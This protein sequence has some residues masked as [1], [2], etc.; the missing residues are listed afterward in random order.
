[1]ARCVWL[2]AA[3][4]DAEQVSREDAKSAERV[5]REYVAALTGPVVILARVDY[6]R[7]TCDN[8]QNLFLPLGVLGAAARK[9]LCASTRLPALARCA[10]F[11]ESRRDAERV[12]RKDAKS[13]EMAYGRV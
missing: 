1:M 10:P 9:S 3:R 2:E 8:T 4:E 5:Y 6:G 12:S 11:E 13:A 7:N